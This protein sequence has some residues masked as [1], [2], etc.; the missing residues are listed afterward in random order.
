VNLSINTFDIAIIMAY[1]LAV[2]AL[3]LWIGRGQRDVADYFLGGRSLPWWALLLSIVATETSTV[4]FLSVPSMSW[5]SDHGDLSF[6]QITFGYIVGRIVVARVLLPLY[7]H[8]APFTAYEVLES[9]FGKATRR[10]ASALFLITRNL[11]D[12]LRLYLTALVLQAVLGLDMA[13]CIVVLGF[14]TILYTFVGGAKSVI[15]NDC[16]QFVIYMLGAVAAGVI[17][18]Q[19]LPG[20][21]GQMIQ[22]AQD[23]QKFH[24]FDFDFSLS[25]PTV[26]FWSGLIG[27]MFLTMA[28]HGTDQ[29]MVQRYLAAR[30]ERDAALALVCSGLIV[31]LQFAI[32]LL[33]GIG[34]ACFYA[35]Y[36]PQTPL[37]QGD[38]VFAH[39]IVQNMPTGLT[40]L[41]L[42]A[43][44]AA[45]MSTLSSSLNSSATA[46]VSDL[47]L[48]L[49]REPMSPQAQ[50]RVARIATVLFGFLQ[51]SIAMM[52]GRFGATESTV[53]SVLAIAGFATGPVL[54]LYW[55]AVFTHTVQQT[56]A[57]VGFAVGLLVLSGLAYGTSLNFLWYAVV[58]SL[59]TLL[60]GWLAQRLMFDV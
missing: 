15:W 14:I 29:L 5:K 39:F 41:T 32:F 21:W 6:L 38:K 59:T 58:G 25:K 12:A 35:N 51:I 46:L 53:M 57:L 9:R 44:F 3:G 40:G 52:S 24:L 26:T 17:L 22:F 23:H 37:T 36:P 13:T 56:S 55:L 31:C 33:L 34:L 43:V 42:A 47:L 1:L 11:S 50:L 30:K 45:A 60:A 18:V 8:G 48:P 20:G 2:L 7:F 10:A 28:T 27:G 4:T 19:S 54:G 49:R 16:V